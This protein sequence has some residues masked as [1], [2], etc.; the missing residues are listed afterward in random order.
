MMK[1]RLLMVLL[2][3]AGFVSPAAAEEKSNP[4]RKRI[5]WLCDWEQGVAEAKRTQLPIMITF[6]APFCEGVPGLW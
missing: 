6:G 2:L 1:T 4:S 5:D 3:S